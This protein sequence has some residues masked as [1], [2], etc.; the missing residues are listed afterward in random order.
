ML[1][2]AA[3]SCSC[4]AINL[5]SFKSDSLSQKKRYKIVES[6]LEL[7][8]ILFYFTSILILLTRRKATEALIHKLGNYPDL[9]PEIPGYCC[10]LV[11]S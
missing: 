7:F 3:I 6:E 2:C 9:L 11:I 10:P 1:C 4:N 8:F 5:K